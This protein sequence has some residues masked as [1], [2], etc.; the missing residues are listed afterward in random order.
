M[1]ELTNV[2][3]DNS[4]YVM[5]CN[6]DKTAVHF[7]DGSWDVRK[8]CEALASTAGGGIF[9]ST[10]IPG[11]NILTASAAALGGLTYL[12]NKKDTGYYDVRGN[13]VY[14]GKLHKSNI[15]QK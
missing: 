6:W 11:I 15:S 14:K 12:A 8:V 9:I 5:A 3:Y 10:L 7:I 1:A 2:E 4:D 13:C